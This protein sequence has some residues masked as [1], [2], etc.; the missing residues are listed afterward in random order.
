MARE[1]FQHKV[2]KEC[3][4]A[5]QTQGH[6][7]TELFLSKEQL[8]YVGG[9]ASAENTNAGFM[10]TAFLTL[11]LLFELLHDELL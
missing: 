4:L 1:C 9:P 2:L 11:S 3:Q 8:K 10:S 7:T 6:S 5:R